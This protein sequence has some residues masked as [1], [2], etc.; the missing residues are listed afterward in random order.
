MQNHAKSFFSQFLKMKIMQ[1]HAK[2]FFSQFLKMKIMQNHF[3]EIM[4]KYNF[5]IKFNLNYIFKKNNI[6]YY[7]G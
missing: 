3:L 7:Y 5:I 6:Y 4:K 2:S 1:N